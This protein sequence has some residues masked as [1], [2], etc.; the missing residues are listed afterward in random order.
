[1]TK[2]HTHTYKSKIIGVQF[3]LL[4]NDQIRTMSVAEI[5]S[6]ETYIN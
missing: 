3:S 1:M 5:T 2:P 4:S 6:K